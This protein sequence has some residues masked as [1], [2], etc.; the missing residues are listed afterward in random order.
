M[1]R[2]IHAIPQKIQDNEKAGMEPEK[3]FQMLKE[4]IMW[5]ELM[6]ES[7]LN[8]SELARVFNVSR[9]PVKEAMLLLQAEGWVLRQGAHFM[10]TPLSLDRIREITEIR[11]VLEVQANI[12]AMYRI[13]DEELEC[14]K[15]LEK[16]ILEIDHSP[17]KEKVVEVDLTFHRILFDAT[18]N[19]Q[20]A[21]HLDRLLCHFLRFW[22]SIPRDFE[23]K[24][25]PAN[26]I[27]LIRAIADKDEARLR[28][29]SFN[30]IKWSM[31]EIMRTY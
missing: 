22:L 10:V 19:H 3:V 24:P 17:N 2:N 5:L 20:L 31:D 14:L 12:W 9:T 30:H 16:Q 27:E 1:E 25:S 13:N 28:V 29:A 15:K 21:Q 7:V 6:P 23:P 4:K 18:K 11:S 26:S 8:I